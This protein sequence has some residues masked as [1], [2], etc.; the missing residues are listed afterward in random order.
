MSRSSRINIALLGCGKLGV[1]I[2]K[3]LQA[4]REKILAQTGLD[5]NIEHI[6][7]K[8]LYFER[9]S[10]IPVAK[11]TDDPE[12]ILSDKSVKIVIDAI[13]GIEPTY[14]LIRKF[15]DNGCHLVSANRALLASKMR[16]IFKL[17][18][19]RKT[20][21]K[22]EAALGGGIPLIHSI[23]RSQI[24]AN[25]LNIWGI[26]SGSSNY[27]L[28]EMHKYK[29][30]LKDTLKTAGLERL[31]ESQMSIDFEGS[32]S[33]QKLALLAA[34]TFGVQ[35]NYLQIHAEGLSQIRKIDI[36]N[37]E[38]FGYQI[39]QLA[40]LKNRP[41]GLELRVH[42][43]FVPKGHP[44]TSVQHDY[45]GVYI[46]TDVLGEFMLYG[47]GAGIYPAASMVLR[48]LVDVAIAQESN[49]HQL[50][51]APGWIDKP[52]LPISEINSRYYLRFPCLDTPGV[53]GQLATVM[54]Q[55]KINIES[56]HTSVK[57]ARTENS[58]SFVHFFTAIT[59]EGQVLDSLAEIRKLKAIKGEIK[60]LRI[61]G[62]SEDV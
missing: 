22:F 18:Q 55:H 48:D 44:L 62:E 47:K 58:V 21:L 42:P 45:N 40:V 29:K 19:N 13:G 6:L 7:V 25:V 36:Q 27:I 8:N 54:G 14:S 33:A 31:S 35:V 53:I 20:Y 39:K 50:L 16:E 41:D 30:S 12:D 61:L 2:F 10:A 5:L 52:V 34:M 57:E 11:I 49:N 15:I 38:D 24:S 1:G 17:T 51:P 4:R 60:L 9:D 28:S 56:A 23:Q 46:R 37:A 32:D 3:L 26:A 59:R 43:T